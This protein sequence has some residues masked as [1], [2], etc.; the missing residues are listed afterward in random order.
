MLYGVSI[1]KTF[2][3]VSCDCVW[4]GCC[5]KDDRNRVQNCPY[6]GTAKPVDLQ[7]R[8]VLEKWCPYM[9][10]GTETST[11]C[12]AEQMKIFDEQILQA[13]AF[14]G[15]CPSCF[16]SFLR[17]FCEMV[18]SEKQSDFI[19]ITSTQK[20]LNGTEYIAGAEVFISE[21]YI[22]STYEACRQVSFPASSGLLAMDMMCGS[23]GANKCT[24][25]RWYEFMGSPAKNPY[26]PFQIDFLTQLPEN[27]TLEVLKPSTF[28]CNESVDAS[29]SPCS[30]IDC[31]QSCPVFFN[32]NPSLDG[33]TSRTLVYEYHAIVFLCGVIF[34]A[35]F[36]VKTFS[37]REYLQVQCFVNG[38][39]KIDTL[40][41]IETVE[42]LNG[43]TTC[44]QLGIYD[45]Q[46]EPVRF[47]YIVK[48][49]LIRL[50]EKC[51]THPWKVLCCGLVVICCLSYGI[52]FVEIVTNPVE[53][54]ASST[55][56]CRKE[57]EYF[58]ENFGPFYRIQQVIVSAKGLNNFFH[59]TSN[60]PVEFGPVFH[61]EF[62]RDFKKLQDEISNLGKPEE[63]LEKICFSP[64]ASR[65]KK[66][67]TPGK[68]LIQSVMGYFKV[69]KFDRHKMEKGFNI[70]Y[71]DQISKCVQNM[72]HPYCLAPYGGPVDPAIAFGG[73][74]SNGKTLSKSS[75]FLK[76]N[77]LILTILINNHQ[78]NANLTAAL[79]WEKLFLNF[80][81]DW[82][83]NNKSEKMEISYFS[84]R[85]VEDEIDRESHTN[86][87]I[88]I[89]SYL[90]MFVYV[91]LMLGNCRFNSKFLL[92]SK[93]VLGLS[94]VVI[95]LSSVISSIGLNSFLGIK[96]TLIA[97]EV[98]PFLVL[99][100][101]VDN[102][103]ILV[104]A[105]DRYPMDEDEKSVEK[106]IG[107]I[108]GNVG[109]SILLAGFSESM[110]FF[111]GTLSDM[112]C[113]KAFALYAAV[114]ILMNIIL[115]L[116]CFVSLL[117][118]DYKRRQ[119]NKLDVFCCFK[120]EIEKFKSTDRLMNFFRNYC[121]P[122]IMHRVTRPVIMIIFVLWFLLS[123]TAM[124]YVE[125]GLDQEIGM[126]G[127]SYLLPY[128]RDLGK[129][130]AV[131]PPVYFVVTGGLDLTNTSVQNTLCNGPFCN[132]DSVT[133]QIYAA[134]LQSNRTFISKYSSSWIDDFFDWAT[135]STCCRTLD[136]SFCEHSSAEC[137]TCNIER[138]N[139]T[140][141]PI[142]AHFNRYLPYFLEDNPD[143]DCAKAGHTA[144]GNAINYTVIG[145]NS[146]LV[147]S[148][149]F[150]AY[151]SV[152]K[153]S[154]DYYSALREARN[155]ADGISQT[156]HSRIE[157][158]E[159]VRVFP[160]S[161]FYIYY[162][163]YLNIW[164]DAAK[165]I[166]I[167]LFAI[168]VASLL[169]TFGNVIASLTILITV[170]MIVVDLIGAMY[171]LNIQL[172]AASLVNVVM[173]IGIA[174]EFCCHM[175]HSFIKSKE[176]SRVTK[177]ID[178]LNNVGSS[179]FCGITLTK[180]VGISV[181]GFSISA[182][183]RIFY[184]QMY[185]AIVMI[186]ALHGII[187]LPVLLSYYGPSNSAH[188]LIRNA[189]SHRH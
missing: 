187:F 142:P 14:L 34:I 85:S 132:I 12:D 35:S 82:I 154:K 181:L 166:G 79:K 121:T 171:F 29:T 164:K 131:G 148:F 69:I 189:V 89:F 115:Q 169:F 49:V 173:A 4:Y 62:L 158:S 186:G 2:S 58:N 122:I 140:N 130:L 134:S 54:W 88:V 48:Y 123:L 111:L 25:K 47:E 165:S 45:E 153:T 143:A 84:E 107:K 11:C 110:C 125:L 50:A 127:D 63:G 120:V 75:S 95:V 71:L 113:V 139:D 61:E 20:N 177:T 152:L 124:P 188:P 1:Y 52:T 77:A 184:F 102:I 168:F 37:K 141:R 183:F 178:A 106:Y 104:H 90:A 117:S 116:T 24:P 53:L 32:Y 86:V 99:A 44:S 70:T 112:P 67:K 10:T 5:N 18:C 33:S 151:H 144:Y 170:T 135:I 31:E 26:V 138:T 175:V 146:S 38:K 109:P 163:Q 160:Y 28:R 81:E 6:N 87:L 133:N 74:L 114:A 159:H 118:L 182:I 145:S 43:N 27:S 39:K 136:G 60:G 129:Y 92:E 19:N 93:I 59:N 57:R 80:M 94:G 13:K 176:K 180:F 51:A 73:V 149:H 17:L 108:V 41:N 172:N 162:E 119:N 126:P 185:M 9:L 68:C 36:C 66:L 103:F 137:D 100:I 15:R 174:V 83:K 55:S 56:Q 97:L 3:S 161:V 76:A 96:V 150:M 156:I 7:T 157:N 105:F 40:Q 30:C 64:F 8:T 46:N 167:S 98:I 155:L 65:G 22:N 101:G 16:Q 147:R 21:T 72:F 42:Y 179:V 91:A 78:E 23:W 128:F